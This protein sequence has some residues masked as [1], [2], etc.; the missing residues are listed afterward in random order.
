MTN[1]SKKI[2]LKNHMVVDLFTFS[3]DDNKKC[4]GT[5][6]LNE[7]RGVTINESKE[8]YVLHRRCWKSFSL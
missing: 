4:I 2:I 3:T 1:N 8:L 7:S 6:I 5:C